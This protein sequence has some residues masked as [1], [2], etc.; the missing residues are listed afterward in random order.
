MVK[1]RELPLL[2]SSGAAAFCLLQLGFVSRRLDLSCWLRVFLFKCQCRARR[3]VEQIKRKENSRS[4]KVK[5]DIGKKK[6]W[7]KRMKKQ[8]RRFIPVQKNTEK[9]RQREE[10]NNG[11]IS[12]TEGTYFLLLLQI[13]LIQLNLKLF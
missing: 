2:G 1:S 10:G 4:A 9:V 13:F 12:Q 6:E 11:N 5:H 8:W 3:K 7:G